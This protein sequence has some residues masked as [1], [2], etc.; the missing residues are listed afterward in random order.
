M[1]IRHA[2]AS[3]VRFTEEGRAA[4]DA[5]HEGDASDIDFTQSGSGAISTNVQDYLRLHRIVHGWIPTSLWSGVSD[6]TNSTDL[7]TYIQAAI[8]AGGENSELYM[9]EGTYK[10][11]STLALPTGLKLTGAGEQATIIKQTADATAL[12][13]DEATET[14]ARN[15]VLEDFQVL[16]SGVTASSTTFGINIVGT[17][18]NSAYNRLAR[19]AV[20]GGFY[21]DFRIVKPIVT[22]I[23]DCVSLNA[24]N[25]GFAIVGDG[26]SITLKNCFANNP[27]RY[28]Y[29]FIGA[30]T[31]SGLD[32]CACDSAGSHAYYFAASTAGGSDWP[33]AIKMASC[34][35]ESNTGDGVHIVDAEDFTLEACRLLSNG[36]DGI[37][38]DGARGVVLNA[39]RSTN[40]TGYGVNPST[41][42]TP[43]IPSTIV[44]IGCTLSSNTAG[45]ISTPS[46]VTE[47]ASTD[48]NVF[49]SPVSLHAHYQTAIPAG[50]TAGAGVLLSSTANFGIFFGSSAPTLSAAKGSLYL[51]TDGTGTTSR[52][53]INT[54]GSTT[55][56]S[57]TTAG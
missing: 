56:T 44:L 43:K 48:G 21:N 23:Q 33:T 3:D 13:C 37:Q 6:G 5:D 18:A 4:W 26:T 8:D 2:Q 12:R 19:I 30:I 50:G 53:Y 29:S 15:L 38:L 40:N 11:A 27:T 16:L 45:R 55:W 14:S 20:S 42:A 51:R 39:V 47:I 17:S 46:R 36:G 32:T 31:Y 1:A 24:A 52:A 57:I 54:D 34:G 9:P 22:S 35:A 10:I 41:S 25:D 28:G 49:A 7:T